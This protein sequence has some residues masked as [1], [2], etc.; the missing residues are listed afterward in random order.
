M[1]GHIVTFSH[2]SSVLMSDNYI[3]WR[4][5]WRLPKSL[6]EQTRQKYDNVYHLFCPVTLTLFLE[7]TSQI[8]AEL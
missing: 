1:F 5:L 2:I 6:K 3:H 4:G 8:T 7:A